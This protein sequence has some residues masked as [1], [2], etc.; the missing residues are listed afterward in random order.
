[1][2]LSGLTCGDDY[3]PRVT[4]AG[5]RPHEHHV[6]ALRERNGSLA[7]ACRPVVLSRRVGASCHRLTQGSHEFLACVAFSGQTLPRGESVAI[8]GVIDGDACR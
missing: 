1:M 8:N 3:R 5:E 7:V 4:A 2:R 6:L